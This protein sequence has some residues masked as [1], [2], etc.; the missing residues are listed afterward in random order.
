[1]AKSQAAIAQQVDRLDRD[2]IDIKLWIAKISDS[3]TQLIEHNVQISNM[4]EALTRAFTKIEALEH[5]MNGNGDHNGIIGQLASLT[6]A[7]NEN[8][9]FR[10]LIVGAI[11]VQTVAIIY[12]ATIH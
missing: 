9:W 7:S 8:T 6:A 12:L 5:T 4:R 3:L 2:V 1:M 10:R 11:L